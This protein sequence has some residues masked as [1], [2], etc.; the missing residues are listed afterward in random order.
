MDSNKKSKAGKHAV[1][2]IDS[3]KVQ[4]ISSKICSFKEAV[5]KCQEIQS[6][7][8]PG[9][10]AL[11]GNSKVVKPKDSKSIDGSVDIDSALKIKYPTES[12][13]DY[14]VGYADEALFIEVHPADTSNV[15]EMVKKVKWLVNWL[16]ISAPDLNLLHKRKVYYWVPSG[17]VNIL[18]G[19]AQYRKI[20]ANHLCIKKQ[21]ILP[22]D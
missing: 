13:W 1:N 9:L 7:L 15:E 21:V 14:V 10:T 4:K 2:S 20:A 16:A 17:R 5:S 3:N 12:R 8:Q 11:G 22:V 6:A 18:K 19:S